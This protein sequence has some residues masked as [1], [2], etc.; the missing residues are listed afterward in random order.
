[1][2]DVHLYYA[3]T[4]DRVSSLLM[5]PRG[6]G[7]LVGSDGGGGGGDADGGYADGGGGG[8]GGDGG[9]FD[10][11]HDANAYYEMVMAM[12]TITEV[13]IMAMIMV[14]VTVFVLSVVEDR[15]LLLLH[16]RTRPERTACVHAAGG[17]QQRTQND[18][19]C[20]SSTPL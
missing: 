13:I 10:N 14:I 12:M 5:N 18:H 8:G 3:V 15:G 11:V 16:D 7:L 17:C 9:N 6:L 4:G 1:M 20:D 2:C 19:R